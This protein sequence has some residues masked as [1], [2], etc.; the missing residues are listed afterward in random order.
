M[1]TP[2]PATKQPE[3]SPLVWAGDPEQCP[4]WI[5]YPSRL[6]LPQLIIWSGA[7]TVPAIGE[8]V[9]IYMNSFGPATVRAYFHAD[10]YMG[11]ICEPDEMPEWYKKQAPGVTLG[12]FFGK[13]L[14][15][16]TPGP[17][18]PAQVLEVVEIISQE[19]RV[20]PAPLYYRNLHTGRIT[21]VYGGLAD[22]YGFYDV[23]AFTGSNSQDPAQL[24][25][26]ANWQFMPEHHY[27]E[28]HEDS[29]ERKGPQIFALRA[30]TAD[31]V[32]YLTTQFPGPFRIPG[33]DTD[34]FS[35]YDTLSALAEAMKEQGEQYRGRIAE[36]SE[37]RTW[38]AFEEEAHGSGECPWE[39]VQLDLGQMPLDSYAYIS[40]RRATTEE[41][42]GNGWVTLWQQ[43]SGQ[44][45]V[46]TE[47]RLH[48]GPNYPTLTPLTLAQVQE[49][50]AFDF[51]PNG[52]EPAPT[53]QGDWIPEY[54]P[55][56]DELADDNQDSTEYPEHPADEQRD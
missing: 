42:E 19:Y 21:V 2:A 55:Q 27:L 41:G 3:I 48:Y 30:G 23:E 54:P 11:V 20:I 51:I 7:G 9:H 10:G 26:P 36:K 12:H 56:G 1:I 15:P 39:R 52:Q 44:Y 16:R 33:E 47:P 32:D 53:E 31:Q 17:A 18:A 22:Y 35:Q 6:C 40:G 34:T 43:S 14:E 13:E 28:V 5:G 50:Y 8:R 38:V 45:Y 25:D 46:E 37:W 49:Q 24:A 29:H 4:K